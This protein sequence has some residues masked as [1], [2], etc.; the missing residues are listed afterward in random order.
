M[1]KTGVHF[2]SAFAMSISFHMNHYVIWAIIH[3]SLS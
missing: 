1:V 2:G 3:G